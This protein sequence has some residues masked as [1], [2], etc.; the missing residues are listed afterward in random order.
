MKSTDFG[1]TAFINSTFIIG[2]RHLTL[3]S[4]SEEFVKTDDFQNIYNSIGVKI[5]WFL[6][7]IVFESFTNIT[8]FF[9]I[10]FEKYGG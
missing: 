8:L 5:V 9:I 10:M 1:S 2:E 3:S 7:W 6:S 4:Q